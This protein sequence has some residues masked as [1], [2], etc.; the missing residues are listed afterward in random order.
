[1]T[2][3]N[4]VIFKGGKD[5]I[6]IMLDASAGF[7]KIKKVL[8][9]KIKDAYMF[10]SDSKTTLT[11]KG[12]ELSEKEL[13][14]LVGII[15]K[16]TELEIDFVHDLTGGF[17]VSPAKAELKTEQTKQ[18]THKQNLQEQL[19]AYVHKGSLRSGQAI[20]HKGSVILLGDM[21]AG[22]QI[23]AAGSIIVLGAIRGMVHA[24]ADGDKS[25]IVC[26]LY[27]QPVQLRIAD[28][29]TYMPPEILKEKKG[30]IEPVYAFIQGE[31]IGIAPI[32]E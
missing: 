2:K 11:F 9:S 27:M 28:I 15:N 14:E 19:R 32:S 16:E 29:I 23:I 5:G 1:M 10:F 4:T 8:H 25:C 22:A 3:D 24:G 7:E 13:F 31:G 30:K 26:A 6:V 21:N 12:K 18:K 17:T 20:N